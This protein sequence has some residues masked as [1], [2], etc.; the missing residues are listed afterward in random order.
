MARL[1]HNGWI[2]S[3]LMVFGAISF[4]DVFDRLP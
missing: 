3:F 1:L 2:H 4:V